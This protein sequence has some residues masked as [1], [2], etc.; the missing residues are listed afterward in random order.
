[1]MRAAFFG[2]KEDPAGGNPTVRTVQAMLC[3]MYGRKFNNAEVSKFIREF[4]RPE[5][6]TVEEH[7]SPATVPMTERAVTVSVPEQEQDSTPR[8]GAVIPLLSTNTDT[9]KTSSSLGDTE[10]TA[11]KRAKRVQIEVPD[12]PVEFGEHEP[13]VLIALGNDAAEN[14][15]GLISE[16]I[17]LSLR[18]RLGAA[19]RRYG[20]IA[21]VDG[22]E[23]ACERG[24]GV[25]YAVG[26]MRRYK[27]PGLGD[28]PAAVSI[29]PRL[30]VVGEYERAPLPLRGFERDK[31]RA[32]DVPVT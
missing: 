11:T 24:H 1:M 21:F 2:V 27:P 5:T 9:E 4:R 6:V 19:L 26:C 7:P 22:L 32:E 12:M 10:K 8:G 20:K 25:A 29:P 16:A 30:R 3:R 13:A 14:R 23:I 31:R 15:D 17:V 18:K 28:M